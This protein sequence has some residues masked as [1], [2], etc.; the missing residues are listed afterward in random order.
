MPY[1]YYGKWQ[2]QEEIADDIIDI[3]DHNGSYIQPRMPAI[4][5]M[6]IKTPARGMAIIFTKILYRDI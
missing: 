3:Q 6:G 2:R 4:N 5:V 1:N